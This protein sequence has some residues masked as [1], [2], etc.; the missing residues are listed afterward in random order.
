L[1]KEEFTEIVDKHRNPE[2]W[3]KEGGE[4]KLRYPLI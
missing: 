2:I 4:W 3:V 1:K